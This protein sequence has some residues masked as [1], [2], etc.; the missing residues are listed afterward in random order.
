MKEINRINSIAFQKSKSLT[1][2]EYY[3]I[4]C[5]YPNPHYKQENKYVYKIYLKKPIIH[6]YIIGFFILISFCNLN[7]VNN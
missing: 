1:D 2:E 7:C 3:E 5:Y 4:V 6:D